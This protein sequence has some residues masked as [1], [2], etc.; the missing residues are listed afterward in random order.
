[1]QQIVDEMGQARPR[2]AIRSEDGAI[3]DERLSKYH[4]LSPLGRGTSSFVYKATLR[5]QTKYYVRLWR[6]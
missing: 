1:M 6:L 4:I 2:D 3:V 5:S